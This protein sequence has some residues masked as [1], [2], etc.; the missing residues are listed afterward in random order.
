LHPQGRFF[1]S[2]RLLL[3][4]LDKGPDDSTRSG[5]HRGTSPLTLP[6]SLNE[7]LQ[8]NVQGSHIASK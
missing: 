6:D 7:L 5:F 8:L 3:A 4:F 2:A 1:I